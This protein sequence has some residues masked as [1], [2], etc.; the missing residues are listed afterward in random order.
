MEENISHE[1]IIHKVLKNKITVTI[2]S[3]SACSSCHANGACNMAEMQEKE[4]D[5][6]HFNGDYQPGQ[7]VNVVGKTKQGYKAVF[8][9][10]L[11]PFIFVFVTLIISGIFIKSEGL[12][13]ILSLSV[14]IP[15]YVVLYFFRNQLKNSFEF[16]IF[17]T[18]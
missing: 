9:G 13:G 5:I 16:E 4:I 14:L 10:Y 7:L 12:T 15:Y 18:T 17:P 8:Y 3:A 11:L 6:Y 1:G 2:V